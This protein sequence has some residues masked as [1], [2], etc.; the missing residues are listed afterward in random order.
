[1][2]KVRLF[3]PALLVAVMAVSLACGTPIA[4][5]P[6][7]ADSPS[8]T[9][10]TESATSPATEPSGPETPQPK[11]DGGTSIPLPQLPIGRNDNDSQINQC[12]K[13]SWLGKPDVPADVSVVVTAVQITPSGVFDGGN[14][15]CGGTSACS[16]FVFTSKQ[17]NCSVRVTAK[18]TDESATMTFQ[19]AVRCQAEH[20]QKCRDFAPKVTAKSIE[21]YQPG[22]PDTSPPIASPPTSTS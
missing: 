3:R 11:V 2:N 15:G 19:G 18:G 5:N 4:G 9:P 7:A 21:L 6:N 13:V 20:A 17:T 16:S 1:M 14:S 8:T 10:T 12:V 22:P